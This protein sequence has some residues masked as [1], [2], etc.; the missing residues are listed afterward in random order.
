MYAEQWIKWILGNN[1][2]WAS[3]TTH[4]VAFILNFASLNRWL[5]PELRFAV[6]ES[7]LYVQTK[8]RSRLNNFQ[9]TH[10]YQII[11]GNI[12]SE[13]L[14]RAVLTQWKQTHRRSLCQSA[15]RHSREMIRKE[16]RTKKKQRKK[17]IPRGARVESEFVSSVNGK[18]RAA[19]S[20]E[21]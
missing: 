13:Q 17:I 10:M 1:Q 9:D 21:G 12:R 11:P 2:E 19:F 6:V 7:T 8:R 14:E 5:A 15:L 18:R 20:F 3:W 4:K 16:Q